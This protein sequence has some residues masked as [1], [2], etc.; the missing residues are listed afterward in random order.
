MCNISIGEITL[1]NIISSG[2]WTLQHHA[3]KKQ[4]KS[5]LRSSLT[6]S[7]NHISETDA[8]PEPTA[9]RTELNIVDVCMALNASACDQSATT[10]KISSQLSGNKKKLC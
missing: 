9:R 2:S 7:G 4:S 6:L 8:N 3:K 5:A 1:I 10:D